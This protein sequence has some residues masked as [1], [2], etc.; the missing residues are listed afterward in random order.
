MALRFLHPEHVDA[1]AMIG[2]AVIG[3]LFNGAAL[4]RLKGGQSLNEKVLSWHL[5]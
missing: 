3:I 5:L 1:N 4:V 2:L